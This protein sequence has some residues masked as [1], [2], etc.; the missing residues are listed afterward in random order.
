MKFIYASELKEI[1]SCYGHFYNW[2]LEKD[3]YPCRSVLEIVRK[4]DNVDKNSLW[5]KKAD[6]VVIMMNPGSSRPIE[7]VL[8][9][10][11][12]RYP[13]SDTCFKSMVLTQ[14]D[15][16]QYQIMRVGIKFGWKHIR[17]LNLSDLR[18]S[19][20]VSFLNCIKI[21]NKIPT[22]NNHS[23]FSEKRIE[24]C[25]ISLRRKFDPIIVGWG[26]DAGLLPLVNQCVKRLDDI[27]LV[28]VISD[29]NPLLNLHPS[30]MLQSAKEN[31]LYQVVK[32]L[33]NL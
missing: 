22:G 18:D 30:P 13:Y 10:E 25:A 16:T 12:R 24:E 27:P 26:Q 1:F 9:T 4:K 23:L 21:L 31:W 3:E 17:V 19:K 33:E 11:I 2:Q 8:E 15:N 6:A 28:G 7:S 5:G 29:L 14:P 32:N 20:S